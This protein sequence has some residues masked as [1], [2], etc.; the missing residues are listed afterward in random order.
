MNKALFQS[1]LQRSFPASTDVPWPGLGSEPELQGQLL[2]SAPD[3][4]RCLG[5]L[6]GGHCCSLELSW[7]FVSPG[8]KGGREGWGASSWQ[9]STPSSQAQLALPELGCSRVSV[10]RLA[11]ESAKPRNVWLLYPCF[12]IQ[13]AKRKSPTATCCVLCRHFST[14]SASPES[15]PHSTLRSWIFDLISAGTAAGK[16]STFVTLELK[17][18]S[19]YFVAITCKNF[20]TWNSK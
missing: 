15:P 19:L 9:A 1:Q 16:I 20:Y 12:S 8:C 4:P 6:Q 14:K 17:C 11:L 13:I 18:L 7:G 10:F 3:W 2:P 5:P